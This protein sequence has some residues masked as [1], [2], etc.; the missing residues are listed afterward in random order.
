MSMRI[1]ESLETILTSLKA[2]SPEK[3]QNSKNLKSIMTEPRKGG[4]A[5]RRVT[6][7]N[8]EH[9]L[10]QTS[11]FKAVK[12]LLTNSPIGLTN[13]P[14]KEDIESMGYL[15]TGMREYRLGAPLHFNSTDGGTITVY[16]GKSPNK[17][18]DKR[19]IVYENGRYKQEMFYDEQGNLT[20]G[21]I[22]IK[23]ETELFTEQQY[24]FT[25]KDNKIQALIR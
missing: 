1:N 11:G 20:K 8:V 5:S 12:G 4:T 19:K 18:E 13:Q 2:E 15:D 6:N 7:E 22:I 14:A 17:G 25:V 9:A 21:K 10:N 23:D 24:D 3:P 16:D